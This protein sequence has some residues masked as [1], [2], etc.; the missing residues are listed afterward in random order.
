M[1]PTPS[2]NS[3]HASVA[4]H[5]IYQMKGDLVRAENLLNEI[6]NQPGVD[7]FSLINGMHTLANIYGMEG[8]YD[9][10]LALDARGL[11]LC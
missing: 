8:K 10:A 2:G 9:E 7:A 4:H 11:A 3:V 6:I 5:Q 1:T